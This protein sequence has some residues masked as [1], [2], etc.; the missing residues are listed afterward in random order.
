MPCATADEY[1]EIMRRN[2]S[3]G[4]CP[5][6]NPSYHHYEEWGHKSKNC[7][8]IK[9]CGYHGVK[10]HIPTLKCIQFCVNCNNWGHSMHHCHK[11]KNCNLCGKVGHNPYRCWT[12]GTIGRWLIKARE[13]DLC[14]NCLSPWKAGRDPAKCSSCGG[15]RG[16]D[17]FP[18][19]SPQETKETQTEENV[20]LGQEC[21]AELQ[22]GKAIIEHQKI[23][24]E[25]LNSKISTLEVKLKSS[26]ATI[27]E[28]N[29][30][31]QYTVQEKEQ[32]L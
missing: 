7:R 26:I 21:Q 25:E 3:P 13:A 20:H 12:Y 5:K 1:D 22:Q 9:Y 27:K 8:N 14:V 11:L 18:S 16:K 15:R 6:C 4:A 30:Q 29:S 32:E 2:K 19:K 24:M 10:G 17:C 28:L 31:W 23:Q